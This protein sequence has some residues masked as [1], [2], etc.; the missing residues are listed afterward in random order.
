MCLLLKSFGEGYEGKVSYD[1][2]TAFLY[3]H[4]KHL[5]TCIALIAVLPLKKKESW[6]FINVKGFGLCLHA[7]R[8]P[9]QHMLIELVIYFGCMIIIEVAQEEKDLWFIFDFSL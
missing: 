2:M 3:A 1:F 9:A 8:L 4:F 6:E 7:G 5:V